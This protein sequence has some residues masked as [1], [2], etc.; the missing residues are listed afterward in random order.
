[1]ARGD[2]PAALTRRAVK[3]LGGMERFVKP[4]QSVIIRLVCVAYHAPV[5]L[6]PT[7]GRLSLS[8]CREAE[9]RRS[10]MDHPFGGIADQAYKISQIGDA[11]WAAG[12]RWQ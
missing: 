7:H 11:A 2:D 10:V 9:P 8:L 3:A 1:V 6:P 4:G 5:L 12:G